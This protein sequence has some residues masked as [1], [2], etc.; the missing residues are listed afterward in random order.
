MEID[1]IKQ[2]KDELERLVKTSEKANSILELY[3]IIHSY[4]ELLEITPILKKL[5]ETERE[6][7]LESYKCIKDSK[8][9]T[10]DEKQTLY[11]TQYIINAWPIYLKLSEIS[12]YVDISKISPD[13]EK[14][15]RT[16]LYLIRLMGDRF[17]NSTLL[18]FVKLFR[19][20]KSFR[21]KQNMVLFT[22]ILAHFHNQIITFLN[23]WELL[24][25]YM[26]VLKNG[27]IE[28]KLYFD[29]VKSILYFQGQKIRIKMQNLETNAHKILK[30]IFI[31]KKHNLYELYS[32]AE[33][34]ED[35]FGEL[36]YSKKWQ[37]Y[38]TACKDIQEKIRKG[39]SN[40]IE[41]FLI[42]TSGFKG[43]VRINP[44]YLPKQTG[45]PEE[46]LGKS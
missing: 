13:V 20:S 30:Y 25:N 10:E 24:N 45:K 34:A 41:D 32:Y 26:P 40:K 7:F 31:T 43:Q 35:E 39:T 29:E 3:T 21:D 9:L 8:N 4:L 1:K 5:L 19:I 12:A 46:F 15:N 14:K 11:S 17:K 27:L 16:T 18:Y 38:Y 36:K 33:I 44:K 42:I 37:K 6:K 2:L 23:K 28:P 22:K